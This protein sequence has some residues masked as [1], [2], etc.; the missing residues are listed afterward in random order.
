MKEDTH[1]GSVR[2][3]MLLCWILSLAVLMIEA[4]DGRLNSTKELDAVFLLLWLVLEAESILKLKKKIAKEGF[5]ETFKF[6]GA[7]MLWVILAF[8]SVIVMLASQSGWMRWVVLLR[9]PSVLRRFN[10]EKTFE[11][12]GEMIVVV[13]ILFFV[14]PFF[15]IIAVALSAPGQIINVIPQNVFWRRYGACNCI[16]E[17]IR[18]DEYDLGINPS[19]NNFYIQYAADQRNL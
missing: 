17:C 4:V 16:D 10:D 9:G 19:W 14:V 15:N 6:N 5:R 18:I 7:E 2:I 11:V 8:I 1:S 3:V 13:L 12:I